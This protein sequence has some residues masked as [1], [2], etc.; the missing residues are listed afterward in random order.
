VFVKY[1]LSFNETNISLVVRAKCD[2]IRT[3]LLSRINI[4]MG[5]LWY[6]SLSAV[7]AQIQELFGFTLTTQKHAF[8]KQAMT[9]LLAVV[10]STS[11][12]L[13]SDISRYIV[14]G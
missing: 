10:T 2:D 3:V 4:V 12:L 11:H 7:S 13:V 14:V 1:F 8:S 6:G 9:Y 5:S